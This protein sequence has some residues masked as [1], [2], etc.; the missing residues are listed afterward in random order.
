MA[1]ELVPKIEEAD[2]FRGKVSCLSSLVP[3]S[4]INWKLTKKQRK[5]FEC[6]C[7]GRLLEMDELVFSSQTVHELLLREAKSPNTDEMWFKFRDNRIRF[8]IQEFCIVTGLNCSPY[9]SI[10]VDKTVKGL[11]FIDGLLNGDMNLNTLEDVFM[12]ASTN[13]DLT[14]V[15][16]ALLYF[17]ENVLLGREKGSTIDSEHILL[18]DDLD[19]FNEYPW[20]RVCFEMTMKSLQNALKGRVQMLN[21]GNNKKSKQNWEIYSVGGF[22]W[23]FLVWAYEAIP[24]LGRKS[25]HKLGCALPR[26][27][28]W[29]TKRAPNLV[30][31]H[32]IFWQENLQAYTFLQPT[33]EEEQQCYFQPFIALGAS[34]EQPTLI[35]DSAT[36]ASSPPYPDE[37]EITDTMANKK[38]EK[39]KPPIEATVVL[40]ESVVALKKCKR[41][42]LPCRHQEI[43]QEQGL[44][45]LPSTEAQNAIESTSPPPLP[46]VST[47]ASTLNSTPPKGIAQSPMASLEEAQAFFSELKPILDE[48]LENLLQSSQATLDSPQDIFRAKCFL[49]QC[50]PLNFEV[51]MKPSLRDRLNSSLELLLKIDYFPS[52]IVDLVRSFQMKFLRDTCIYSN[53]QERV[54]RANK[55]KEDAT[56]L[57]KELAKSR[58]HFDQVM[59]DIQIKADMIEELTKKL[60]EQMKLKADLEEQAMALAKS[61][62]TSKDDL[63]RCVLNCKALEDKQDSEKLK[64]DIDASWKEFKK[65]IADSL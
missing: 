57:R 4:N 45:S 44:A 36:S 14:M 37:N 19:Q 49:L 33:P 51:L 59:S 1:P 20:G 56:A 28:N 32:K 12:N 63:A 11:W 24:S 23:G 18:A 29:Q 10:D 46:S 21:D 52:S 9:P 30:E 35:Q 43:S 34:K 48:S 50:L 64:A 5:M 58:N 38:S 13:D 60:E 16:L 26:L 65:Q 61:S 17:L 62:F 39:R 31:L 40:E 15:K 55:Y 7:F 54:K 42:H 41:N 3:V 2:F 27:F 6:T 53:C 25:A 22:P 8:S 47:M